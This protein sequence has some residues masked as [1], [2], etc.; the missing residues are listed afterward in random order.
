M[1]T[2]PSPLA[3]LRS[4]AA[5]FLFGDL[6]SA[7]VQAAVKVIDDQYWTSITG[8][9]VNDKPWPTRSSELTDALD[10]WRY[11]PL[12]RRI[13]ALTTDYVV[14]DGI[15]LES[16]SRRMQNFVNSFWAHSQ[17]KM[18]LRCRAWCDEL[19]RTG[20]LFVAFFTNQAD[21]M[22]YVRAIPASQIDAITTAP[23][24]I[25]KELSYHQVTDSIKG[26]TWKAD[27][28]KGAEVRHYA[29]NRVVG[30]T[31]GEGDLD[32][33]LPWLSDYKV[34]LK[35][36]VDASSAASEMVWDVTLTGAEKPE[37]N[38][39][40]L[41]LKDQGFSQS[42]IVVHN[43]KEEWQGLYPSNSNVA[44]QDGH[45]LRMMIG[46][47]AGV[48][49]HFLAEPEGASRATAT[50]MNGPTFRHFYHRQLFFIHVLSDVVTRAAQRAQALDKLTIPRAG[51]R[52][53]ANLAEL[54]K[55][56]NLM[57]AQAA[58]EIVT[59]LEAAR[60]MNWTDD[61]TAMKL[62]YKFAGEI[63]DVP[64]LLD[65]IRGQKKVEE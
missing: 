54:T 61:E 14:G 1:S 7:R 47:G 21:G 40:L 39:R 31:R 4:R 62:M 58:K 9:G 28:L 22:T 5:D 32:P 52:L 63:V 11:N 49:L 48:P 24:D 15:Q 2:R 51:L 3:S 6:I 53:T 13:V 43:E 41:A 56:D 59:A 35:N 65:K 50:E 12:A 33:L 38:T 55:Q 30:A 26:E 45:A 44:P 17:N 64:E 25:E 46:A 20:E 16:P 29:V 42:K 8:A 23:N 37:C 57:L 19:T 34:W 10:A 36:R 27:D 18:P 60:R